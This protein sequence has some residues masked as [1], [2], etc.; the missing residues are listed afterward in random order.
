MKNN[1]PIGIMVFIEGKHARQEYVYECTTIVS[2]NAIIS[3]IYGEDE[4]MYVQKVDGAGRTT[5]YIP[6]STGDH[7]EVDLLGIRWFETEG[8]KNVVEV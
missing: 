6:G 8:D 3:H 4:N 7:V 1:E 2:L 5:T